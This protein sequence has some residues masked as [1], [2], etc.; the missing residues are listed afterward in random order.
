LAS[1][2]RAGPTHPKGARPRLHRTARAQQQVRLREPGG[3]PP[4]RPYV[5]FVC[6]HNAGRSRMA[7]ALFNH[8][9]R[10]R[11][12]AL[13][14]GT[15][16][17]DRPHREVLAAMAEVGIDIPDTAGTKLSQELADGA[18]RVVGMGCA[19]EEA[20]P[21][22]KVPL[23]NWELE[24]PKGQSPEKV[25]EIRDTIELRVRNLIGDLERDDGP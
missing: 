17:A 9:G 4:D 2:T 18:E 1:W 23:D 7:E 20:C 22:L 10:G 12:R 8:M 5:L 16:P 11:Y 13:S 6:V 19:V 21:A 24:D 3:A 14:A 25:A 15:E